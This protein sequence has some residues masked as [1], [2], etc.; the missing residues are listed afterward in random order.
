MKCRMA[1]SFLLLNESKTVIILGSPTVFSALE[2]QFSRSSSHTH[3]HVQ[4]SWT[5]L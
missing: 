3:K 4:K 5:Y 2:V 1:Y